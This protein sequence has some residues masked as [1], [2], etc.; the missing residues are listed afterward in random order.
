MN[1]I[2]L[3]FKIYPDLYS[4]LKIPGRFPDCLGPFSNSLTFPDSSGFPDGRHPEES[5]LFIGAQHKHYV[6]DFQNLN[7]FPFPKRQLKV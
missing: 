6:V 2:S 3:I 1:T 7:C 4:F 5:S